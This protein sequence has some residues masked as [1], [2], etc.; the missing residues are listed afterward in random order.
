MDGGADLS[1]ECVRRLAESFDVR[2]VEYPNEAL[3]TERLADFVMERLEGL[4]RPVLV[5]E[6]FS[7]PVA[8][9]LLRRHPASFAAGVV[10]CSFVLPPLSRGW[11]PFV[12]A[13]L[14]ARPPPRWAIRRRMVGTNAPEGS[15]REVQRAIAKTSPAVMAARVRSVLS[16]DARA[17][18]AEVTTPLLSI[19]ARYDRLVDRRSAPE[20][21][22]ELPT[23]TIDAPH[24]AFHVRGEECAIAIRDW[25]QAL[26]P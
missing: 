5:A 15:V 8:I 12:R 6:S 13:P 19:R 14:F 9:E 2:A 23:V 3:S 11:R 26:Q 17:A 16:V 25:L 24:L 1:R 20:A 22:A 10:A 4:D 21:H 18:L 7:G